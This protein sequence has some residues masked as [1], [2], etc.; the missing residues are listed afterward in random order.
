M[1]LEKTNNIIKRKKF[2]KSITAGITGLI[3]FNSF[4]YKL[5]RLNRNESVTKISVKINPL[6]VKRNKPGADNV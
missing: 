2:F 1:K 6:A 4:P 5:F 3:V